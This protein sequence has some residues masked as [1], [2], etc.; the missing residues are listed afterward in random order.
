VFAINV[1]QL[2]RR[3]NI[4]SFL[5]N[6]QDTEMSIKKL[7]LIKKINEKN[8]EFFIWKNDIEKPFPVTH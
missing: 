2:F 6:E 5:S 1:R 3:N 4:F 7:T 8:T